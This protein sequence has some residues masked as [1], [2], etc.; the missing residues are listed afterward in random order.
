ML[1]RIRNL[2][3][4]SDLTQVEMGQK[5][6]MS[7]SQYQKYESGL[8]TPPIDILI[9]LTDIYGVSL[10]YIAERTNAKKVTQSE[11]ASA[12]Y[13]RLLEY[14]SRLSLEDQDFIMGKMVEL[15]REHANK[16]KRSFRNI[17]RYAFLICPVDKINQQQLFSSG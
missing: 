17:I 4:D 10:D 12:K 1:K 3:E 6:N 15:H 14:Y 8:R 13:N 2:R 7:Q 11:L 5:L 16:G 9:Q